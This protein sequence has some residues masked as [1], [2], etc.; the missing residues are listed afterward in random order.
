MPCAIIAHCQYPLGSTP[1]PPTHTHTWSSSGSYLVIIIIITYIIDHCHC[2]NETGCAIVL[3]SFW[4]FIRL[5]WTG[6]RMRER[7]R[8]NLPGSTCHLVDH[9][10]CHHHHRQ[11]QHL[12]H[13]PWRQECS[14]GYPAG[15][16]HWDWAGNCRGKFSLENWQELAREGKI[17]LPQIQSYDLLARPLLQALCKFIYH[18]IKYTFL[19]EF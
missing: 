16:Y 18:K 2:P 13:R 4:L 1:H 15:C 6:R 5:M 19:I 8:E 3:L 10:V 14:Q 11:Q 12:C 17:C 7:E 9:P